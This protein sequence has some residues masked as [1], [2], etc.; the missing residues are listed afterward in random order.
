ML[1]DA[2][3]IIRTALDSDVGLENEGIELSDGGY[4]WVNVLGI[5]EEKQKPFDAVKE[6]VK[7]LAITTER[8][9]LV[10]ELA[11]KLVERADK[12]ESMEALAKEAAAPKVE[13]TPP[14]TRTTEPHGLSKDAAAKAFTLTKGKA[15]QAPTTDGKARA[16]FKL[17]EITPAGEPT[18]EEREKIS[19]ELKNQLSD[20]V[21]SEY[22]IALQARLGAHINQ[23]EYRRAIGEQTQ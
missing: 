10:S 18:K 8:N 1:P 16:V 13:T 15:G 6:E 12:G 19:K 21:L 23:D 4:A 7:K 2:L 5:T 22:V 20:E 17:T 9:R 14:F 11:T 3:S